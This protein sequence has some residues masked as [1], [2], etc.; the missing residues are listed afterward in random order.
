MRITVKLFAS[1]RSGRFES[2]VWERPEGTT[3]GAI[4]S[5]LGIREDELGVVAVN[6]RHVRPSHARADGDT[7]SLFPVIGGG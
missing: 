2:A 4:A 5:E 1:F 7:C 6:A 3:V